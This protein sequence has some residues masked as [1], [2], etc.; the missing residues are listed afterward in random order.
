MELRL[1]LLAA[2]VLIAVLNLP[3]RA[4]PGV[5]WRNDGSGV[6]PGATPPIEWSA[7]PAKNIAWH[8]TVG[9]SYSSPIVVGD[10]VFLTAEP[11]KLLCVAR[12]D[13]KILWEKT[14]NYGDL[15]AESR[16]TE[17]KLESNCGYTTPTPVSDGRNVLVVLGTGIVASYDLDGER[18]WIT[19]LDVEPKG[20]FGRSASPRLV[21][22]LLIAPVSGLFG[23][24]AVTGR[25]V[26]KSLGADC[27]FGA[28]AVASIGG[29]KVLITPTGSVIRAKD[30][31]MLASDVGSAAY[32]SPIVRDD[33]VYFVSAHCTAVKLSPRGPDA[34]QAREIW[35]AD[36]DGEFFASPVLLD[37]WL[38]TINKDGVYNVIDARSGKVALA[39]PLQL[40]PG[41]EAGDSNRTFVYPSV[42]LAGGHLFVGNTK[43]DWE[44]LNPAARA[45]VKSAEL[46]MNHLADGSGASPAFADGQMFVR[47]GEELYCLT[48][49]RTDEKP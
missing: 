23:L 27:G 47:S 7:H 36:L 38:Y 9:G 3:L 24:D 5:S 22:G 17:K 44:L 35:S 8:T 29:T 32:A 15:P 34:V 37:N 4:G 31:K 49:G 6:F 33:V 45:D 19:W 42:S 14:N 26:W 39:G 18:N 2:G 11:D 12:D 41:G 21:D 1:R 20:S 43:G 48:S 10:R 30:G 16:A 46:R 28:S 13:G 40:P 25:V